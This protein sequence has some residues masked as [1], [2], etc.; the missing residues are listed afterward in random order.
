MDKKRS[1]QIESFISGLW[2]LELNLGHSVRSELE[3]QEIISSDLQ[4]FTNLLESRFLFGDE[5]MKSL[6]NKSP[7]T[8]TDITAI[9]DN[10]GVVKKL[11]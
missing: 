2:D 11:I 9:P 1:G 3:E 4:A 7:N 8:T 10:I 5:I 6:P